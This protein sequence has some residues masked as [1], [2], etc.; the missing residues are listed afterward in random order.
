MYAAPLLTEVAM[1]KAYRLVLIGGLVV[2]G[3]GLL[4]CQGPALWPASMLTV[5]PTS[6]HNLPILLNSSIPA[7]MTTPSAPHVIPSQA[8]QLADLSMVGGM[9]W[10]LDRF[11]WSPTG[12]A[13]AYLGPNEPDDSFMAPLKAMVLPIL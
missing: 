2:I 10:R 7:S 6:T 13:L 9:L 4:T 1:E 5:E 8:C 11:A 3:L 12:D